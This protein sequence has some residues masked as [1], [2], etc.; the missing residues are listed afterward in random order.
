LPRQTLNPGKRG[1][2]DNEEDILRE[3]NKKLKA[4][5]KIYVSNEQVELSRLRRQQTVPLEPIS[6]ISKVDLSRKMVI[7]KE[8]EIV[9]LTED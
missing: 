9:D 8:I 3:E 4:I 5:P 7:K 6:N 2:V 1:R